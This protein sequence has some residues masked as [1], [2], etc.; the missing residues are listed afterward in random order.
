MQLTKQYSVDMLTQHSVSVGAQTYLAQDEQLLPV[1]DLH[2]T[3]FINSP[4]GRKS[5]ENS[6]FDKTIKTAILTVWGKYPTLED[7][8]EEEDALEEEDGA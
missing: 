5:L 2:R 7:E 4:L 8:P 1:G 3:A 6:D